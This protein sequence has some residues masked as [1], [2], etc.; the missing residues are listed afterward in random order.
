MAVIFL[1]S[2]YTIVYIM[3]RE[4]IRKLFGIRNGKYYG[5]EEEAMK[6]ARN[7]SPGGE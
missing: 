6:A 3:N 7:Y 1:I 2:L 4:V 5:S